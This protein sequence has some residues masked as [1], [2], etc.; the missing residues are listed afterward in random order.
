MLP[1]K[2]AVQWLRVRA[3]TWVDADVPEAK[4]DLL[5]IDDRIVVAGR[6]I[7][8]V[9]LTQAAYSNETWRARRDPNTRCQTS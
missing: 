2:R 4:A 3:D 8:A 7:V 1:A 9:R 5:P 6:S